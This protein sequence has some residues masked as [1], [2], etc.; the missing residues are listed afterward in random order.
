MQDE[1]QLVKHERV[2][3]FLHVPMKLEKVFVA[4]LPY[5]LSLLISSFCFW[6]SS[7]ALTASFSTLQYC[8][9]GFS[10]LFYLFSTLCCPG[11][12]NI[13]MGQLALTP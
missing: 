6:D 7:S 2:Y 9:S 10:S 11:H 1:T 4:S 13:G 5:S 3:N 12:C 8:P